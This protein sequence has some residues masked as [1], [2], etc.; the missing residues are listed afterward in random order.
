LQNWCLGRFSGWSFFRMVVFQDGRV[1]GSRRR[2]G[3]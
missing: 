1:R 3:F 2:F